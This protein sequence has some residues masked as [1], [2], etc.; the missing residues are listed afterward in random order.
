ME[1]L[2]L[3]F[4]GRRAAQMPVIDAVQHLRGIVRK[5]KRASV[6]AAVQAVAA[7]EPALQRAP[8]V[9]PPEHA[10]VVAASAA[11]EDVSIDPPL[12][13]TDNIRPEDVAAATGNQVA[14]LI[15][16]ATTDVVRSAATDSPERLSVVPV[17]TRGHENK[18]LRSSGGWLING[19]KY[20][21]QTEPC[22]SGDE[23][24]GKWGSLSEHQRIP[25][26]TQPGG[27]V[28]MSA[29]F[30][31]E[32]AEFER[33]GKWPTTSAGPGKP[34]KPIRRWCILCH[35]NMVMRTFLSLAKSKTINTAKYAYNLWR[36]PVNKPNGYASDYVTSRTEHNLIDPVARFKRNSL[37][38]RY[39]VDARGEVV[40]YID[41]SGIPWKPRD[42]QQREA[43]DY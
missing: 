34:R 35:R 30:V 14:N 31:D 13:P 16:L 12:P 7:Q 1:D 24:V 40:W 4:F 25:G 6:R 29:L 41:Q 21:A 19:G 3:Y 37:K 26:L 8:V 43:V 9:Q 5:R 11:A 20:V 42:F 15:R 32:L 23:C 38:A 33:T 28:L 2:V 18:L 39:E 10:V 22:I 17:F 36:N 27:V